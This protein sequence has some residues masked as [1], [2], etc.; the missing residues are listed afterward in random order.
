MTKA[1]AFFE[2][3]RR[4]ADTNNFDYAI[5]MFLEGLR[6]VPDEV[7]DG[8]AKLRAMALQRKEKG[9]K[10]PTMMEKVKA[11]R[12][13]HGQ[14][15][16][17]QLL[18]AEYLFTKEPDHLPYAESM[19]KAA[20]EGDYKQT[21]MWIADLLFQLNNNSGKPSVRTYIF[22]KDSYSAIGQFDRALAACQYAVKLHPQDGDLADEFRRL[23]AELTVSRGKYDQEGDF[24]NSIKNREVQEKLQSQE[25]V[26]KTEDYRLKAIEDAREELAE[27]PGVAGHIFNLA[28]VLSDMEEDKFENEAIALL[29]KTSV[30]KK[31]FSFQD[32]AGQIRI[33]QI[34]R[35]F[36]QAKDA[37]EVKPGDAALKAAVEQVEKQLSETRREHY[38]LC[39]IN[40]PTDL[41]A[42]YEYASCLLQNKQYDEA[43]PMFQDASRDPRHKISAS[44]KIGLCFYLKGWYADAIDVFNQAIEAYELTD[45]NIAKD[46]RYNLGRAFEA[47]GDTEQALDIYRKIAQLDFGYKDVRQRVD[48]LRK[49]QQGS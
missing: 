24:R 37:L 14:E 6:I 10:G 31:D 19:L 27:E 13:R 16:I 42:K 45:D 48:A 12:P 5:D 41:R 15:A 3:A 44:G 9:G 25:N 17:D 8:H 35:K 29:E 20:V 43:I 1:W 18:G 38:R 36:R 49:K 34:G 32:R 47:K 23:S 39:V 4:A 2:K 40:Y 11:L 26:I 21:A 22:L 28:Q 33:R 7:A 46:L 30:E